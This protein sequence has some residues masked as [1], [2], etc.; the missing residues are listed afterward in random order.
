MLKKSYVCGCCKVERKDAN[1]WF[2][3]EETTDGF[4]LHPWIWAV[5]RDQLDG[6]R[7]EHVCGQVCA[8]K[9]LD[10]FMSQEQMG[11]RNK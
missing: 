10:R 4:H 11:D 9:L 1:H 6:G 2:V 5:E 7:V 3:L 8:H